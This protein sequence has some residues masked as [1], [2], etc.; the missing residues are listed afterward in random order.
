MKKKLTPSR[1]G[2]WT[3]SLPPESKAPLERKQRKQRKHRNRWKEN[4]E[5]KEH[6]WQP[7]WK[8]NKK[9]GD[10]PRSTCVL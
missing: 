3:V 7:R 6:M 1:G 10:F 8:E 2:A 4:K 5:N 9:T